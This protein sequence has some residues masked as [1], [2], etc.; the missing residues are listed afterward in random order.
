[1]YSCIAYDIGRRC[2]RIA[3]LQDDDIFGT[4]SLNV[5]ILVHELICQ[6]KAPYLYYK[7]S[8][9]FYNIKKKKIEKPA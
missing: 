6:R 7:G 2:R 8:A 3:A 4:A 1:M 9:F 5:S